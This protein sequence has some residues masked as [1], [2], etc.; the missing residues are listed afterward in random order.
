MLPPVANVVQE[1]EGGEDESSYSTKASEACVVALWS[2]LR[3]RRCTL[4]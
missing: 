3:G 2:R 4:P 1:D